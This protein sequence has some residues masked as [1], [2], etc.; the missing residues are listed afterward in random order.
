MVLQLNLATYYVE[1]SMLDYVNELL[2]LGSEP[3]P[4]LM[5]ATPV[6]PTAPVHFDGQ[7]PFPTSSPPPWAL[8]HSLLLMADMLLRARQLGGVG[9]P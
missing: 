5:A 1:S 4:P 3:Q 9:V 8:F 6:E 7:C 2:G